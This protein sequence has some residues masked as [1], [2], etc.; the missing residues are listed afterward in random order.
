M[1]FTKSLRIRRV[2]LAL[3]RGLRAERVGRGLRALGP[4]LMAAAQRDPGV[5]VQMREELLTLVVRM[6]KKLLSVHETL[7]NATREP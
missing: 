5:I 2:R 3:S 6:P 4:H 1:I 7:L